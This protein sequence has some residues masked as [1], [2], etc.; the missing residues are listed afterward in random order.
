[1]EADTVLANEGECIV[2]DTKYYK[3]PLVA[4]YGTDKLHS[5]NLYQIISYVRNRQADDPQRSHRGVLLY[6]AVNRWF[7]FQY[8]MDGM[9]IEA[10][11]IDLG[12]QWSDIHARMLEV[13][14]ESGTGKPTNLS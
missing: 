10:S 9:P 12:Q 11:T 14:A 5:G 7:S 2:I 6:P 8:V 1:M 4:R 3:Q 13:I